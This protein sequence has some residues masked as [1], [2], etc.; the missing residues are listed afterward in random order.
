MNSSKPFR[1][2]HRVQVNED[3]SQAFPKLSL[4]IYLKKTKICLKIVQ[5]LPSF[6]A[7]KCFELKK[8]NLLSN[9][10]PLHIYYLSSTSRFEIRGYCNKMYDLKSITI[11]KHYTLL[12][13]HH[14]V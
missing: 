1:Y 13:Y 5:K 8:H 12:V 11:I 6:I 10:S 14:Q 7:S 4:N 9:P 3:I 2:K